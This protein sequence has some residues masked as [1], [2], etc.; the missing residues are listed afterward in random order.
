MRISFKEE[1]KE[2]QLQ[3]VVHQIKKLR[4]E[5]SG[6]RMRYPESM[7]IAIVKLVNE[8]RISSLDASNIFELSASTIY[9][10]STNFSRTDARDVKEPFLRRLAVVDEF[11]V[12]PPAAL[13]FSAR[14]VLA[15]GNV[16]EIPVD[17]LNSKL[18]E[19]LGGQ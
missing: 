12:E 6:M 10:W 9:K 17:A 16:L 5:Y 19:R 11:P 4:A 8:G 18:L 7:K 2:D 3:K 1:F 15:N 13:P 14:L